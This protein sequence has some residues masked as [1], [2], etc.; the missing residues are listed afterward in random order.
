M[1]EL[2]PIS[3]GIGLVFGLL[4]SE[5]FGIAS[6]GL[7][8]PG[9]IALYLL[10]PIDV[11][12]T[13]GVAFVAFVVVSILGNFFIL[14]GRRRSSL[15]ILIGY[16]LGMGIR[17]WTGLFAGEWELIGYI[18]PGL[19]AVWMDRQGIVETLTALTIVSSAVRLV[20]VITLGTEML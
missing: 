13:L 18:I 20:L 16:L 3:I 10:E 12:L 9:Y 8:V 19:I 14:F 5:L 6:G 7:I 15:M 1:I 2:L 17:S 11:A 4:F